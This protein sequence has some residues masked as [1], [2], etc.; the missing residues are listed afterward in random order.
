MVAVVRSTPGSTRPCPPPT[1]DAAA[2]AI[3]P[4]C[5]SETP[6]GG[7]A[8]VSA[9]VAACT[10]WSTANDVDRDRTRT[11]TLRASSSLLLCPE[12]FGL[13]RVCLEKG[14]SEIVEC[15][16]G[17][18][19]ELDS[20]LKGAVRF[21][22]CNGVNID[23][24]VRFRMRLN[25]F[26]PSLGFPRSS[27]RITFEPPCDSEC[28]DAER[29]CDDNQVCYRA[30]DLCFQCGLGSRVECSCRDEDQQPLAEC[31]ECQIRYS[32]F[33]DSGTCYM[34]YCAKLADEP[35]LCQQCPASGECL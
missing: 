8:A 7:V 10:D 16:P 32:D 23:S 22:A 17:V 29:R 33:I 27:A 9:A 12:N 18:F 35:T 2:C 31:T 4:D 25:V 26:G 30:K 3:A 14:G 5:T 1:A 6:V 28:T 34:G 19:L 20:R 13:P 21:D 11:P 24:G 15:D